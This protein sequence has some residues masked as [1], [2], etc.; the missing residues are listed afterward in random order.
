MEDSEA[1]C[2]LLRS[3][4]W[5]NAGKQD[6]ACQFHMTL[7]LTLRRACVVC[8]S[9]A[10]W[11]RVRRT[12]RMMDPRV[13]LLSEQA[14]REAQQ[15]VRRVDAGH[16]P[17]TTAKATAALNWS[18]QVVEATIHP[19]SGEP[20][21]PR[22]LRLSWIVPMNCLL[23]AGM[24]TAA[25]PFA[26]IA[27]Q[28]AN[29][30]YN[31]FHYEA[32]R[33]KSNVDTTT[34]R[35]LAYLFATGASVGVALALTRKAESLV[36]RRAAQLGVAVRDLTAA[37]L[38]VRPMLAR[39]LAPFAAVAAADVLNIFTMRFSEWATEGVHL[40]PRRS[41]SSRTDAQ[42]AATE[43]E[44]NSGKSLGKSKLAGFYAV[45]ACTAGRVFAAAPVLTVPPLIVE[46]L[47]RRGA[48]VARPWARLPVTLALLGAA[49][50]ISVPLT[51][52]LFR[53][54]AD[55]NVRWLEPRFRGLRDDDGGEITRVR[56]NKGL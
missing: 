3:F 29:Q 54:S 51:F 55:V 20:I 43:A 24:I 1:T 21:S 14:I 12:A 15:H 26:V 18:R 31:A 32:N 11:Q 44:D 56:Y 23:D 34:Q 6:G 46:L 53:Q 37:Q 22:F 52:G 39:R 17:T 35:V 49:I 8:S 36:E 48:F 9:S 13:A 10:D 28:W 7:R 16:E 4:C 41:D 40:Y 38:G 19:D 5:L 30:S 33:N 42:V 27:S 25:R 2:A 47:E 45:G 50:Q